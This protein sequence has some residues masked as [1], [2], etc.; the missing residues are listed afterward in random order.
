M[1]GKGEAGLANVFQAQEYFTSLADGVEGDLM[2]EETLF[3]AFEV[4]VARFFQQR[5]A[6]CFVA[7]FDGVA[8]EVVKELFEHFGR[9][10]R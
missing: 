7:D 3:E 5:G 1:R 10:I 4:E 9:S 8:F 2:G 6:M